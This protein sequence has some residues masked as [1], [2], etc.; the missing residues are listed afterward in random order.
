M[1]LGVVGV[2]P[3]DIR[4]YTAAQMQAIAG[5]GFSGFGCHL[6][7]GL[8]PEI[9]AADCAAFTA[10]HS[11][12]GLELVQFSLTYGECLFAP[13]PAERAAVTATI[14][15]GI[16]LTQQL[17][18]QALL[19]RPGSLNPAGPFMPHRDN[20]RPECMERLLDTLRPIARQAEAADV[21]LVMESHATTIMNSPETCRYI[22]E[23]I[24]SPKLR[25]TMDVVNHI[26]S[27]QQVY[28]SAARIDQIFEAMGPIAPLAHIKDITVQNRHVV[29]LDEEI[30]G[31]GELDIG[32]MLR[33][34]HARY[35]NGYGL[36][37]HLPLEKVPRANANVRRIATECGVPIVV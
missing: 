33:R 16:A 1:K 27:L 25:L 13:N 28:S 23:Q 19:I 24:G 6:D 2:L 15:R 18:A 4:T 36:I 14:E 3:N 10:L 29:H 12:A 32:H 31:D 8:A 5:L 17:G 7:G 30:P 20:H 26:Q 9:T 11:A 35:P 37:E 34:F 21:L 22:V